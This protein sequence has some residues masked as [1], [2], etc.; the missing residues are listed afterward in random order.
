MFS[1]D[2]ENNKEDDI[3]RRSTIQVLKYARSLGAYNQYGK[4]DIDKNIA[5]LK[6]QGE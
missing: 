4:A 6:K 2:N 3:R 5:W 1:L